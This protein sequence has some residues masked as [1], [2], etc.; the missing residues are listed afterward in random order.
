MIGK[1]LKTF[2]RTQDLHIQ[3]SVV[4]EELL[5]DDEITKILWNAGKYLPN[6]ESLETRISVPQNLT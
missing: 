4:Q 2:Q 3:R 5:S 6:L 1:E